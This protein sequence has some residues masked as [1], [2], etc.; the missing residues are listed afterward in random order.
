MEYETESQYEREL[1]DMSDRVKE[2]A[3]QTMKDLAKKSV[4]IHD[5]KSVLRACEIYME[6]NC[7]VGFLPADSSST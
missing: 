5:A 7:Q 1:D 6:C 2:M 4:T 3:K